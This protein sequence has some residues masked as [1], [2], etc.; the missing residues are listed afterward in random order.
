MVE[1]ETVEYTA[2]FFKAEMYF[3]DDRRKRVKDGWVLVNVEKYPDS[4]F[5]AAQRIVATYQR[6]NRSIERSEE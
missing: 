6:E 4:W 5:F 2:K 1:Q 3:Y